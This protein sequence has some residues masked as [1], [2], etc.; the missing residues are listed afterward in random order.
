LDTSLHNEKGTKLPEKTEDVFCGPS[1]VFTN[2]YN[3]RAHIR[4][5]D[6]IRTTL[7]KKGASLGA[8]CT[9]ICGHSIGRHAFVGAG[10]V[11]TRDVPDHALV[12][13]NPARQ[14]GWMCECGEK[15]EDTFKGTKCGSSFDFLAA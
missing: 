15:L 10:A 14:I 1:M 8:Y 2:V 7:I 13:G 6:E 12:V 11:V 3:P 5:M 4:R 9:I